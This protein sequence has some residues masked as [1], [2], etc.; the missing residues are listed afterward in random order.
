MEAVRAL[1]LCIA[2]GDGTR[3]A[4]NVG[5]EWRQ[6]VARCMGDLLIV[7]A[8]IMDG[9]RKGRWSPRSSL[10][11]GP[12]ARQLCVLREQHLL[13][14]SRGQ[15]GGTGPDKMGSLEWGPTSRARVSEAL[16]RHRNGTVTD[17]C[18]RL[19]VQ[20]SGQSWR[21]VQERRAVGAGVNNCGTWHSAHIR[22][23]AIQRSI[24]LQ[25]NRLLCDIQLDVL[26]SHTGH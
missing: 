10:P 7:S 9:S 13:L 1:A 26:R 24:I 19:E 3:R 16:V 15:L 8:M 23:Y 2:R 25:P 17:V 22:L 4:A 20:D 11:R 18:W 6:R 14:E 21:L 12:E 5:R